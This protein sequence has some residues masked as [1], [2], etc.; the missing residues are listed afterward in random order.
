MDK[1]Y[2][3][4]R[5]EFYQGK[6]SVAPVHSDVVC[7]LEAVPVTIELTQDEAPNVEKPIEIV[8]TRPAMDVHV[9]TPTETQLEPEWY[10][11]NP[12]TNNTD[13]TTVLVGEDL[14]NDDE[15]ASDIPNGLTEL[16]PAEGYLSKKER[17]RRNR[18][19]PKVEE[20]EVADEPKE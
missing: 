11:A 12:G 1:R 5:S 17:R 7:H 10:S 14:G 8:E 20:P 3:G 2:G 16:P 15:E 18:Q 19:Q 6:Q 13:I 4:S 9:E